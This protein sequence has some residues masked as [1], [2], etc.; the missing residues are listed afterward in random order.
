[1]AAETVWDAT[2]LG[3]TSL[4]YSIQRGDVL[5]AT[6]DTIGIG[7]DGVALAVPFLPG[8][9]GAAIKATRGMQ[10]V[11]NNIQALQSFKRGAQA[12]A[13]LARWSD[14]GIRGASGYHAYQNDSWLGMGLSA[15][16]VSIRGV[17]GVGA[18]R[19]FL[20]HHPRWNPANWV[21]RIPHQQGQGR[22]YAGSLG[23]GLQQWYDSLWFGYV[24]PGWVR[25]PSGVIVPEHL[26]NLP[27]P[28]TA[29]KNGA[30]LLPGEGDVGTYRDLVNAGTKG[31][32]ITPHHIPSA[33]HMK[34]HGVSKGDGISIN[35]EHSH[36]GSGG[37]HRETFT[38]G[39]RAD[40]ALSPRDALARGV[41]DT[42]RIYEAHGLYGP[43][44]RRAL[45]EL[46]LRNKEAN[47]GLFDKGVRKTQ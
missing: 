24:P 13:R 35:M 20:T 42:K 21:H 32:D 4:Y 25:R 33:N 41:L 8:G 44:I 40:D 3:I 12:T 7:L 19:N 9:A 23:G 37:R 28:V 14:I 30:K 11:K 27:A 6:I 45:Q 18:A 46:I 31:D 17:Q 29:P 5:G 2:S 1:M 34:Q 47:P 36:P 15:F 38:Y 39:T 43:E 22:V 10:G 16:G 26:A